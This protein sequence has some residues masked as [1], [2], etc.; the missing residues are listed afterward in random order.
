MQTTPPLRAARFA[1]LTPGDLFICESRDTRWIALV[2]EDNTQ[3]E[4]QRLVLPIG[5]TLPQYMTYPTLMQDFGFTATSYGHDFC[6]QWPIEPCAWSEEEPPVAVT[7]MAL[8]E[9]AAFLRCNFS[10]QPNHFQACFVDLATGKICSDG[11]GASGRYIRPP[12]TRAFASRWA[13]LTLEKPPR[14]ILSYPF[15]PGQAAG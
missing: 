4:P 9:N 11:K 5:P 10:P 13:L 2:A 6:L 1:Q 8:T 14:T 7:A 3:S 12:G 15:A